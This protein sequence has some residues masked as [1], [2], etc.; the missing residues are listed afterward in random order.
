M[1]FVNF[2]SSCYNLLSVS[3]MKTLNESYVQE[4]SLFGLQ[5]TA[6]KRLI[7][8]SP[9]PRESRVG[10]QVRNP[11]AGTEAEVLEEHC[12]QAC[13]LWLPSYLLRQHR[14]TCPEITLCP[15]G[16]LVEAS[17][18]LRFPPPRFV[19]VCGRLTKTHQH[20][21]SVSV[22]AWLLLSSQSLDF[23]PI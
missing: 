7:G 10:A 4:K 16:N 12:L 17:P 21:L 6:Q 8:Y 9:P 15:Q 20:S 13:F 11:E 23:R 1:A 5:I 18:Q 19:Q 2:F 22:P 3:V 14:T